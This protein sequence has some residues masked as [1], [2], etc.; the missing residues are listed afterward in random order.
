[1]IWRI[2]KFLLKGIFFLVLLGFVSYYSFI[3]IEYATGSDFVEYINSNKEEKPLQTPFDFEL[4]KGDLQQSKLLLVGEIHGFKVPQD[5]DFNLFTHI[6]KNYGVS[7]YLAE[8]DLVQAYYLNQYLNNGNDSVLSRVLKNWVVAQ[9]RNNADYFNKYVKL[10]NYYQEIDSN[11]KF[12]FVGIDRI[13]DWGLVTHLINDFGK[14]NG[15]FK[16]LEFEGKIDKKVLVAAANG[17]TQMQEFDSLSLEKQEL[18]RSLLKNLEW[19]DQKLGRDQVMFNNYQDYSNRGFFQNKLVY[20]YFGLF[21]V[22]QHKVNN[23]MSFAAL[24]KASN[25]INENEIL[26]IN[27]LMQDSYMVMPS[28]ALPEFMRTGPR[29]SKMPISSDNIAFMYLWGVADFKR[30]VK[31]GN[32]ALVKMNSK[33]NN[34]Y[35]NSKRLVSAYRILPVTDLFELNEPGKQYVQYSVFVRNS[36]W[37]EPMGI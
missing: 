31:Q 26:S 32:K 22:M 20:G 37:A 9:G 8:L 33:E 18:I 12:A 16:A 3:G 24:V 14:V 28:K 34:P 30:S 7:A 35:S 2:F 36:D 27:F 21:H 19:V 25:L 5:F 29:Y 23:K 1:M 15:D 17:L 10:K 11:Q 4:L 6:H 13:Q